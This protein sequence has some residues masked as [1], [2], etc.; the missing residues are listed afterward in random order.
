MEGGEVGEGRLISRRGARSRR[1]K[2]L[3]KG[4]WDHPFLNAGRSPPV[5][6]LAALSP[7]SWPLPSDLRSKVLDRPGQTRCADV[8]RIPLV[9]K[10]TESSLFQSEVVK[11]S[12][13]PRRTR[14][15]CGIFRSHRLFNRLCLCQHLVWLSL[16]LNHWRRA[17]GYR[18]IIPTIVK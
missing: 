7:G 9:C 6:P 12:F 2:T 10:L 1:L 8:G 5:M 15:H 16:A 13:T 3:T 11:S 4:L 14:L 18:K 17:D